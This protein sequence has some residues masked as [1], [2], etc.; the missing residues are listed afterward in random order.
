MGERLRW[1][2]SVDDDTQRL[3]DRWQEQFAPL[4][5]AN[6]SSLVRLVFKTLDRLGMTAANV[7]VALDIP[8][9]L[10][11]TNREQGVAQC[12]NSSQL[13]N[14]VVSDNTPVPSARRTKPLA[15]GRHYRFSRLAAG[16]GAGE[17]MAAYRPAPFR[18]IL[19]PLFSLNSSRGVA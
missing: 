7:M 3:A 6:R 9:R 18:A 17:E 8:Q 2:I 11:D 10:N 15:G 13:P 4:V 16:L 14:D 19:R 5:G 12:H 1:V